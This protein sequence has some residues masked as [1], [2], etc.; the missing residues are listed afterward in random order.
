M[1][2]LLQIIPPVCMNRRLDISFII[3][4]YNEENALPK[5]LGSI[6]KY[7]PVALSYEILVADNG[8]TDATVE[9][10]RNYNVDV[11]ID[12]TARVGSLRNKAARK[13]K[14]NVFV[15]LD[16]DIILTKEW[17][18]NIYEVVTL[19]IDDP[20]V[21]TGSKCGLSAHPGWV[22]RYWFKPLL[23]K[24]VNYINSGHLITSRKLFYSIGGFDESLETGEDYAFSQAAI[25]AN[26]KIINNYALVVLHEGYPKTLIQFIR[27]EIWHGRGDCAS[28][29]RV[30][31]SKVAL[32]SILFF[33]LNVLS[34]SSFAF[35]TSNTVGLISLLLAFGI[36]IALTLY[37]YGYNSVVEMLIVSM[38]FYF[39]LISRFFS[40]VPLINDGADKSRHR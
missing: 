35:L 8:S 18:E 21:V 40:C 30:K 4:A 13:A 25:S 16:A 15:F 17:G 31:K 36:C 23:N 20:W 5:L 3:P 34:F 1:T 19:L 29:S 26:A 27:R 33:M 37:R 14:G 2:I 12:A 22:E 11:I 10:A 7:T 38:L 24:K 39:Y 6:N 32:L 9:T 28:L